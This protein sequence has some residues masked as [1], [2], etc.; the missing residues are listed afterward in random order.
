MNILALTISVFLIKLHFLQNIDN[1]VWR[2]ERKVNSG[3]GTCLLSPDLPVLLVLL[4]F[5]C[6]GTPASASQ[7]VWTT[8]VC[9]AYGREI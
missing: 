1:S 6:S 2:E 5:L 3:R 7:V 8:C 9:T 4:V